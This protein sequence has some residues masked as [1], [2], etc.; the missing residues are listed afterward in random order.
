MPMSAKNR[1]D[2]YEVCRIKTTLRSAGCAAKCSV[3][4]FTAWRRSAMF[5]G[6]HDA[7]FPFNGL[8]RS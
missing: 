1:T 2:C 8:I 6:E 4:Y 3:V 7:I 5:F